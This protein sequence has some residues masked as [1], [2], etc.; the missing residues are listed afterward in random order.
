ML[1]PC[2]LV[3][4]TISL[5]PPLCRT[6]CAGQCI[7][8]DS[9]YQEAET[10]HRGMDD[11]GQHARRRLCNRVG[12]CVL[13]VRP[14][15]QAVVGNVSALLATNPWLLFCQQLTLRL[16]KFVRAAADPLQVLSVPAVL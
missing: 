2:E 5:W 15:R 8:S 7:P 13:H 3:V 1:L 16:F 9:L 10:L 12:I 14:S 11:S 6:P 4:T